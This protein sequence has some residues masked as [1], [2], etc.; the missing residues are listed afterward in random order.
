MDNNAIETYCEGGLNSLEEDKQK[1]TNEFK[2]VVIFFT[3]G[4][5]LNGGSH[6][7]SGL[8]GDTGYI[9]ATAVAGKVPEDFLKPFYFFYTLRD[10][11]L[12][13]AVSRAC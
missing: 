5:S 8:S 13:T 2:Y 1:T 4:K 12:Y 10:H 11:Q 6:L 9:S 7:D 3:L